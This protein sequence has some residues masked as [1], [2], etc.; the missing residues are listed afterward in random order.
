MATQAEVTGAFRPEALVKHRERV[1]IPSVL[2]AREVE[3]KTTFYLDDASDC[4]AE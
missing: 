4:V 1:E 2:G 3:L